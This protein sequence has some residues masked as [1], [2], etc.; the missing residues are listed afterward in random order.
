MIKRKKNLRRSKEREKEKKRV[1]Q[2]KIHIAKK[3]KN[4]DSEK[5]S[6]EGHI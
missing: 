2:Q 4:Y 5:F 3:E 6:C 1:L